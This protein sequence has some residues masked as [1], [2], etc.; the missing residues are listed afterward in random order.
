[1]KRIYKIPH[2]FTARAALLAILCHFLFPTFSQATTKH[3]EAV[4]LARAG[5]H[6]EAIR[7]LQDLQR[8]Q[9]H[10][11]LVM[12]DLIVIYTWNGQHENACELYEQSRPESFKPYVHR[13]ILESYRRLGKPEKA[14]TVLDYL[15]SMEPNSVELQKTKVILLIDQLQLETARQLLTG[16]ADKNGKDADYYSKS[17]L[18]Y[19]SDEDWVR[20]L[21]EYQT[22]QT[23]AGEKESAIR[24][25]FAT[26]MHL[27]AA[28]AATDLFEKNRD[29]FTEDD[30]AH[31]LLNQ[32][33][34]KL[35]WSTDMASNFTETETLAI[36]ALAKQMEA[37]EL[38]GANSHQP[39]WSFP[40]IHDIIIT[41]RN[42]R[43]MND[44]ERIYHS[45]NMMQEVPEYVK[46]AAAGAKLANKKPDEAR[47]LYQELL[48]STPDIYQQQIGLFYSDV[49][50]EDFDGAYALIDSMHK[51]EPIYQT[52]KNK[53]Q[54]SPN[55]RYISI[56]VL[57]IMARYYADELKTAW[58]RAN[59]LVQNAPSNSWLWEVRGQI[60]NSRQWH[61]QALYDYH[62][63]SLLEPKSLN[64]ISGEAMSLIALGDFEAARTP[65]QLAEELYPM[66]H[67]TQELQRQ[68]E[69]S[70]KPLYFSD[71]TWSK[72]SG[73]ETDGDG[74]VASAEL[75]SAP[76]DDH[77]Y[78]SGLYRYAWAELIKE[79]ETF[80]RYTFGADYL[81]PT[82]KFMA[83]LTDNYSTIEEMGGSL[84][85]TWKPDDFWHFTV[86]AE[87]FSVDTPLRA[88]NNGIRADKVES[89]MSYRWSEQQELSFN[90]RGS[91]FTDNNERFEGRMVFTHR[92]LDIPHYDLDA[93]L[94]SS[95]STN[96]RKDA[97]YFNPESDFSTQVALHLDHVYWRRYEHLLAQQI[98]VGY[99]FYAQNSYGTEAVGHIR[100]EQ[101]YKL[102]PWFEMLAGVEFGTGAYDGQQEPYRLIR[103]M[104][105]GKM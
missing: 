1:M 104:I 90:V 102:T 79:E 86:L 21:A 54:L 6:S 74:I 26:L 99:G 16:L 85:A 53:T 20:A 51:K 30:R 59:E 57:S 82:L 87:R 75:I 4:A 98:D 42:L 72:S 13:A 35:R 5:N 81:L 25:Q 27:R 88:L 15:L 40:V 10:N 29:I 55:D 34:E 101:R 45:L 32:A 103:L 78:I 24:Q 76:I 36:Q 80:E 8:Q 37:L 70:R 22:M 49:E 61:H 31:L 7:I 48:E 64:A 2:Q 67:G 91:R 94:E 46:D 18:I 47:K 84:A 39:Q 96:S 56:D 69:F 11:Q 28:Q 83:K 66:E 44:V 12:S 60:A 38:L 17:A 62:Y 63:A 58:S 65:L 41:L 23:L 97:P 14:V 77:I 92:L 50:L 89:S 68:W 33:A 71:I 93:R 73:P 105:S 100:Y 52:G 9:P 19:G 95:G 43:Q 3:D